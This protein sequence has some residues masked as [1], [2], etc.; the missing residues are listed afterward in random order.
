MGEWSPPDSLNLWFASGFSTLEAMQPAMRGFVAVTSDGKYIP[1]LATT[2]PTIA[3]GGVVINGTTFDVKVTLKS[4]LE[5]SDGTPLTM[6]DYVATWKW[7]T[8][9]AQ[10][11]CIG[12]TTGW[13][14]IGGI[15]ESTDKLTATIHFKDL[16][17]GW[18]GFLT[19]GP[20]PARY[21]D[22]V[23]VA[24]ASTLYPLSPD[25]S[26]VP[27]DGPF[28]ITSASKT[29]IDYAPNPNWAGGVSTPHAPF[30]AG[31][32]FVYY[33]DKNGEITDFLAGKLDLAFALNQG[34]YPAIAKVDP[35]I[36]KAEEVP[37]WRYEHL[38]INN[39]PDHARGNDLWDPAV[40]KALAMAVD[41]ANLISVLF[42]GQSIQPA[43][44]PAPPGLWYGVAE[45]CPAYDPTAAQAALTAAGLAVG[46]D[47]DFQY[48]GKDLNL[49][50]CTFASSSAELTELQKVQGY[51]AAVHVKSY[52][53]TVDASSV[54][55]AAWSDT[56]PTTDCSIYRG[57]YDLAAFTYVVSG[58]PYN[59]DF[60]TYASDQWPE[61]GDHSGGNDTRFSDPAMDE[62]LATLKSAVDLQAQAD[63]A[64]AVQD[65]YI[66][67]T[68]EIP[69]F[70]R[71]EV[72][73]ISSHIGNWPG[74]APS[75]FGEL[76]NVEDWFYAP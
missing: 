9:K 19:S 11:G 60:Y 71:A 4:G 38:D 68:P 12:C 76:W 72:T 31:L 50:L 40:R 32:K 27:F 30:L 58:S 69:L 37:V 47:G 7:A 52:V 73:G 67:G 28:V 6:D 55:Y 46:T 49:E 53:K 2:V 56:T 62:A 59:D 26:K 33:G 48:Q 65:A 24:K 5:W 18:L 10:T 42:P 74:Y 15:D 1:D 22:S 43:C 45:T 21:L 75:S 35:S 61:K 54:L 70:Y 20:W 36:G 25:V 63:A 57:N 16:Y 14:D 17:S 34:D 44:S 23:P 66:A 8:D 3:N 64:K 29:E 41:K 13:P 39:D 51:L